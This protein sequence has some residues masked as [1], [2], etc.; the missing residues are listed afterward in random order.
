[1]TESEVLQAECEGDVEGWRA[2]YWKI[3]HGK[4]AAFMGTCCECGAIMAG[5]SP[6]VTKVLS[7]YGTNFGI[8][9]QIT[10]D[11]LDIHGDPAR[12]G[13][14]IASDLMHGKFTL[15]VLLAIENAQGSDRESILSL[16]GREYLSGDEAREAARI[17]M[18]CGAARLTREMAVD[19]A[20]KARA[21]LSSLPVSECALA[22]AVL[23]ESSACR[24]A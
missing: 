19:C 18:S 16:V 12:T 13:K 11:L 15:P 4:T 23:A 7:D 20:S 6:A 2:N 5:A 1:M 10:D 22:L 21:C 3:V 24:E 9:F 8:A 14:D 17:V